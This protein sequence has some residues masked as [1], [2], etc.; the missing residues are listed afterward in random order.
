LK[1]YGKIVPKKNTGKR[2]EKDKYRK[3]GKKWINEKKKKKKKK[4]Q[5][6]KSAGKKVLETRK[7]KSG[8]NK[9]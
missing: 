9:P 7:E 1:K 6:E 4:K 8:K 3:N 2:Y 5:F